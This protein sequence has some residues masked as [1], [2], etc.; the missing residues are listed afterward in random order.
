MPKP[1]LMKIAYD[2]VATAIH[3]E[4]SLFGTNIKIT[5]NNVKIDTQYYIHAIINIFEDNKFQLKDL[6][7]IL[8]IFINITGETNFRV[9]KA[10]D[11][12][13]MQHNYTCYQKLKDKYTRLEKM[14]EKLQLQNDNLLNTCTS[15]CKLI[16]NNN[17]MDDI[18]SKCYAEVLPYT[19]KYHEFVANV[20]V[21]EDYYIVDLKTK[22]MTLV[23]SDYK[24]ICPDYPETHIKHIKDIDLDF[25]YELMNNYVEPS[26]L[27]AFKKLCKSVFVKNNNVC[28]DDYHYD[29]LLIYC[30]SDLINHLCKELYGEQSY[31]VIDDDNYKELDINS[32]INAR[33]IFIYLCDDFTH[34][35]WMEMNKTKE[36]MEKNTVIS[37]CLP[38]NGPYHLKSLE[39]ILYS[40]EKI[41][42]MKGICIECPIT[43]FD[44]LNIIEGEM[45]SY[46]ILWWSISDYIEYYWLINQ[47]NIIL[48]IRNVISDHLLSITGV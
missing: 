32:Y 47:F 1:V 22:T 14:N 37:H 10:I 19:I 40:N 21:N 27:L 11:Y 46:D 26:H 23:P 33:V 6:L 28:F 7:N 15:V 12:L 9:E 41:K 43:Y 29:N 2:L 39:R 20:K 38:F 3:I 42:K 48:D 8:Y 45:F 34:E 24:I 18:L 16:N 30:L 44:I 31:Y 5:Y 36:L 17:V 35:K 13:K 4:P 25:I